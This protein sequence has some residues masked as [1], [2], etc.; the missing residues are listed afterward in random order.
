MGCFDSVRVPC[1]KCGTKAE[2]QSKGGA[3]TL[4]AYELELAP[5]EVISDVNRHS[6]AQCEKCGTW[7]EVDYKVAMRVEYA[8]SVEVADPTPKTET[9]L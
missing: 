1:P 4:A 9:K 8:R 6:P 7:F 3:C 5:P 2:F